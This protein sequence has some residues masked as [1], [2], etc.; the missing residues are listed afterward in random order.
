M[1]VGSHWNLFLLLIS[2]CGLP[3]SYLFSSS[4]NA[5]IKT[6]KAR[7]VL[8]LFLHVEWLAEECGW[9]VSLTQVA[10]KTKEHKSSLMHEVGFSLFFSVGSM[11]KGWENRC[12]RVRR[13]GDIAGYL[14]LG[15]C[16]T[17]I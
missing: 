2:F 11:L 13:N 4:P 9:S 5:K 16:G 6:L 12:R 3:I 15:T 17:R 1:D 8:C 10:K 7:S 14:R